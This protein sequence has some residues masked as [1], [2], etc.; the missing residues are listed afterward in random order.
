MRGKG[1]PFLTVAVFLVFALMCYGA[2]MMARSGEL[3]A[4]AQGVASGTDVIVGSAQTYFGNAEGRYGL[5]ESRVDDN[6]V[7]SWAGVIGAATES[8]PDGATA[9]EVAY[10]LE[11]Y[12]G[13]Y[14]SYSQGTL[15]QAEAAALYQQTQTADAVAAARIREVD[16]NIKLRE[17][18]QEMEIKER[19]EYLETQRLLN[20]NLQN[21]L[22][23][24]ESRRFWNRVLLIG[25]GFVALVI[26]MW[27]GSLF[28]P[29]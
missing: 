23:K 22:Q 21:E 7:P 24:E 25:G 10:V 20:Q 13:L 26:L 16:A 15:N 27:L 1:S 6:Y 14:G 19:E 5:K 3:G 28:K 8:V 29:R 17:K 18:A 12:S 9:E 11:A 2:T 4:I